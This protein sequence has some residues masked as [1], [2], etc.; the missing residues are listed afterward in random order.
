MVIC[1]CIC[2]AVSTTSTYPIYP[3]EIVDHR[4]EQCGFHIYHRS[5]CRSHI[6]AESTNR[7]VPDHMHHTAS[8]PPHTPHQAI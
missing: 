7:I 4:S 1:E 8:F 6:V 2:I 5:H 3:I